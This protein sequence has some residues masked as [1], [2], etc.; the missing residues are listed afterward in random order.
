[1]KFHKKLS[2]PNKKNS[3]FKMDANM[4]MFIQIKKHNWI[5]LLS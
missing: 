5:E 2:V 3:Q 1:M 4:Q